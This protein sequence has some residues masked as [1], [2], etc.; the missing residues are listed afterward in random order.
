MEDC[1]KCGCELDDNGC[2]PGV[3][4]H[5]C[6]DIDTSTIEEISVEEALFEVECIGFSQKFEKFKELYSDE[7][8]TSKLQR[9]V[10][11]E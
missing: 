9:R 11:Y 5:Q 10:N 4:F 2:D 7:T 8:G 6:S 1:P 3:A